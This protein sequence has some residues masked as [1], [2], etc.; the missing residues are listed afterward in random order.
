[1]II[2]GNDEAKRSKIWRVVTLVS[3]VLIILI[4]VYLLTRMFT[5]NPVVGNWESEDA[6]IALK[7]EKNDTIQ[8]DI[9]D[10]AENTDAAVEMNY[11]VDMKSKIITITKDEEQIDKAVEK[12]DGAYTKEDL[13][14]VLDDLDSSFFIQ[15][16]WQSD[17]A[18]RTRI[19]GTVHVRQKVGIRQK[20]T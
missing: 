7:I 2:A 4:A 13:E 6:T 18:Y 11:S 12:A 3:S 10:I 19:W 8:V 14:N 16:R 9:T 17:D 1:M 20:E 15:H 5:T